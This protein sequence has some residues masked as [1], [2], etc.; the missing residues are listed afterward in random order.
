MGTFAE[1]LIVDNRL[2]FAGQGKQTFLRFPFAANNQ[3]L[4]ISLVS[5]SVRGIAE[6]WRHEDTD[7]EMKT[8]EHGDIET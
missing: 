4:L 2:P 5:F 7:M 3:K 1:T 6:T 8:C